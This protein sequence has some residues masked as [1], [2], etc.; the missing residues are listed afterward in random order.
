MWE[1]SWGEERLTCEDHVYP[2]ILLAKRVNPVN[3]GSCD[4]EKR[5]LRRT[6]T[7]CGEEGEKI[8]NVGL[9]GCVTR[10]LTATSGMVRGN[11]PK[12]MGNQ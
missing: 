3:P 10:H 12:K 4:K 8:E 7:G 5:D 11:R 6:E 9:D 1:E 2:G